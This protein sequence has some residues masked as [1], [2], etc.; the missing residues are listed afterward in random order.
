MLRH[1]LRFAILLTVLGAAA[2]AGAALVDRT[3]PFTIEWD[4][5]ILATQLWVVVA[6]AIFVL[7]AG[8]LAIALILSAIRAPQSIRQRR[9][10]PPA[11]ARV[12]CARPGVLGICG[13]GRQ[14]SSLQRPPGGTASR[15]RTCHTPTGSQIAGNERSRPRGEGVFQRA[16]RKPR[17]GRERSARASLRRQEGRR[18]GNG[19]RAGPSRRLTAPVRPEGHREL[20]DLLARQGSWQEAREA[21]PGAV[22]HGAYSKEEAR[23]L[24]AVAYGA[25]AEEANQAH[26]PG[27]ARECAQRAAELAPALSAPACLAARLLARKGERKRAERLLL[28]AWRA[29]PVPELAAT[30]SALEP[31]PA[32][33]EPA[34]KHLLRLVD[35]NPS[36]PESRLI[37]AEIAVTARDWSAAKAALGDLPQETPTARACAAMAAIEKAGNG[38]TAAA[39]I[40]LARALDAPRGSYWTCSGCG[41]IL[42]KWEASCRNAPAL[43]QSRE[44][45]PRAP[46]DT[47][48]RR[49]SLLSLKA[50]IRLHRRNLASYP[51]PPRLANWWKCPSKMTRRSLSR[52]RTH[53]IPPVADEQIRNM[54][55]MDFTS[56]Q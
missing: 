55:Q 44:E 50:G 48:R 32:A 18:C 54:V 20:F 1:L 38:N 53:E 4:G 33:G 37:S 35:A 46:A 56:P 6:A 7:I 52:A 34:R 42:G 5:W 41:C 17:H 3:A 24:E 21:L 30:W 49:P 40:W 36:H 45:R 27:R 26:D 12:A 22:R 43:R 29:E 47:L 15:R 14:G 11:G 8:W 16:G 9:S 51:K 10:R 39:Q 25:E 2:L 19:H 31:Q 28:A 13:R 23:R